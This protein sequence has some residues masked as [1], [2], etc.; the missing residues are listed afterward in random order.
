MED[1]VP[2]ETRRRYSFII[3]L[4]PLPNMEGVFLL[5]VY[6]TMVLTFTFF[7]SETESR[8]ID[9]LDTQNRTVNLLSYP[10]YSMLEIPDLIIWTHSRV[11][12]GDVDR[13]YEDGCV[14]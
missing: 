13:V 7:D 2:Q 6:Q 3:E 1:L 5:N 11:H 9:L 4:K 14:P 12:A 10:Q 8:N